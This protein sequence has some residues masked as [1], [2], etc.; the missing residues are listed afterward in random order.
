MTLHAPINWLTDAFDPITLESLNAKAAMMSRI[1]NKYVVS[2]ARLAA[3]IPSLQ[4]RFDILQIDDRR[5]F[6]YD[7]RYFDDANC[8]AYHQHQRGQRKRFKVRARRYLDA[9]LCYLEVKVKGLRGMTQKYR[10]PYD[11]NDLGTLTRDGHDFARDT[12]A[13]QYD[14]PF[15]YHLSPTLDVKYRRI[16]LVARAGGERLTIDTDLRFGASGHQIA[17]GTGVLIVEAKSA[18]GR[19]Y[20]DVLMRAAGERPTSNCSKYCVGMAAL[21]PVSR[22]NRFLPALRKLGIAEQIGLSSDSAS[23]FRT[24]PVRP[25]SMLRTQAT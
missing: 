23:D 7:T 4:D 22:Y 12:F 19:G 15:D 8:T 9:G 10:M 1:D 2:Q 25:S 3:V 16:T 14:A 20:A 24:Q 18:N 21:R 11:P 5:D 6:T 13:A 17:L